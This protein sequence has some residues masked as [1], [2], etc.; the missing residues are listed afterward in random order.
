MNNEKCIH[1][2]LV[3]G[4]YNRCFACDQLLG[5]AKRPAAKVVKK[6]PK[7][8]AEKYVKQTFGVASTS[9]LQGYKKAFLA[10][11]EAGRNINSE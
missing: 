6:S 8:L 7:R 3:R 11:F 10:G 1:G 5:A 2:V 4:F 9:K